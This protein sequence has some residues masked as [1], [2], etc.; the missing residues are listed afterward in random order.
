M[1]RRPFLDVIAD[2][3]VVDPEDAVLGREGF[4]GMPAWLRRSLSDCE[5]VVPP[6]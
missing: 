6:R 5:H 3:L 4:E 2:E 1:D